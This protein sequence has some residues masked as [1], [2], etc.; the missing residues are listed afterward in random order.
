MDDD[1][2]PMFRSDRPTLPCG[3]KKD[4]FA[5]VTIAAYQTKLLKSEKMVR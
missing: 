2:A 1:W 5:S 3:Y 4:K